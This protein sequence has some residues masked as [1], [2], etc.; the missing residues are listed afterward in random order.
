MQLAHYLIMAYFFSE[1]GPMDE[2]VR[3]G[4]SKGHCAPQGTAAAPFLGEVDHGAGERFAPRG[5]SAGTMPMD[6]TSRTVSTFG[7]A[8]GVEQRP[9]AQATAAPFSDGR[10]STVDDR[11]ERN[12]RP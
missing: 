9:G 3:M 7:K 8:T 5:Q 11:F 2:Q 12:H 10:S 4:K 1:S 6:P